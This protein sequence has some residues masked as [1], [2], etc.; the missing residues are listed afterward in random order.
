V[1]RGGLVAPGAPGGTRGH[2]VR[3]GLCFPGKD[4]AV[5]PQ[6]KPALGAVIPL[7]CCDSPHKT[8]CLGSG[9]RG[10]L[11]WR[12][13][14]RATLWVMCPC[15]HTAWRSTPSWITPLAVVSAGPPVTAT[16]LLSTL[17][18]LETTIGG[19]PSKALSI[20]KEAMGSFP[21]CFLKKRDSSPLSICHSEGGMQ[22]SL[23]LQ[24]ALMRTG[25]N[26][27]LF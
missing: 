10:V 27:G 24:K 9:G 22:A 16:S 12:R 21:L 19:N 2:C 3:D 25:Q 20:T 18:L 5:R 14:P 26:W 17:R 7:L 4:R 23:S 6:A 13:G 1:V 15:A 11:Q 8:L